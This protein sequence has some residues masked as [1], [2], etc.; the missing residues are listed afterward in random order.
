MNVTRTT[1]AIAAAVVLLTTVGL[2]AAV[3]ASPSVQQAQ[4]APPATE[5]ARLYRLH[6]QM[7]HG[8]NGKAPIPD[9]ALF[10]RKWKHGTSSA[11]MAKVIAEGVKGTPMM[12]FKSKLK[13]AQILALAKHVRA[14]DPTLKPEK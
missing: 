10:Q 14:F 2:R 8:A 7:C 11:E 12:P 1:A 5:S 4:P 6:C 9:M 3:P 13:P